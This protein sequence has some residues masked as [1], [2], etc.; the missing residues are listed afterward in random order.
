MTSLAAMPPLFGFLITEPVSVAHYL[1]VG[2]IMFTAGV[3]C[4]AQ[5]EARVAIARNKLASPLP[6]LRALARRT[7]A[8]PLRSRLCRI[9][10]RFVYE[11]T[12]L[13][14]DGKVV[15]AFV[16]ALDGRTPVPSPR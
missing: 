9:N 11:M 1:V 4:M 2:A 8:E 16:D 6:A 7:Q 13:R 5:S 15:R 3:V 10:E 14:R 12:M